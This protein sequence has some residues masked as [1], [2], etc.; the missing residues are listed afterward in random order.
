MNYPVLK[1]INEIL[2]KNESFILKINTLSKEEFSNNEELINICIGVA[3]EINKLLNKLNDDLFM[4]NKDLLEI[5]KPIKI[6]T[7]NLFTHYKIPNAYKLYDLFVIDL[8]NLQN[9][10]NIEGK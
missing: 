7:S 3:S 9:F 8:P 10:L 5:I 4:L 1:K 6:Y 2:K